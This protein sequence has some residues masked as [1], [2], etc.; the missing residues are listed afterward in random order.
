M[1]TQNLISAVLSEETK[2]DVLEKL[3]SIKAS[4]NFL[5]TLRPDQVQNLFKAG[6]GYSAFLEKAYNVVADHPEILSQV[7]DLAE[8]KKDYE[9]SKNLTPIIDFFNQMADTLRDTQMAV[10][11][12]AITSA[13]EIYAAVKLHRDRVPGLN[14]VADEMAEFFRRPRKAAENAVEAALG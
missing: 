7:L 8:F 5:I 10:N 14:V 4:V 9:L 11:S 12:D 6:N 2:T 3:A 13:L 1:A